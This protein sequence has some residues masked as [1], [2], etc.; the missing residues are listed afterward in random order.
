MQEST[1]Y[2]EKELKS[3]VFTNIKQSD[4]VAYPNLKSIHKKLR[5]ESLALFKEKAVG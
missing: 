3:Q 5:D 4:C 2:Y 1:A